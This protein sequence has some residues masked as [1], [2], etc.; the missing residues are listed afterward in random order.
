MLEI[1]EASTP[2]VRHMFERVTRESL[3]WD[4]SAPIRT[5]D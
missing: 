1:A 2:N 5:F 3:N 4:G